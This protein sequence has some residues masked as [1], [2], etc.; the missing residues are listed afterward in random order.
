VSKGYDD[1]RRYL[2]LQVENGF[3]I[4]Q[5]KKMMRYILPVADVVI[6]VD[7]DIEIKEVEGRERGFITFHFYLGGAHMHTTYRVFFNYQNV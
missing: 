1:I 6:L 5:R 2:Y 4:H 7:F 3:M